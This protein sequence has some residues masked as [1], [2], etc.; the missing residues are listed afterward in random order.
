MDVVTLDRKRILFSRASSDNKTAD[1][2]LIKLDGSGLVQL[3]KDTKRNGQAALSSD[4]K[5]IVFAS[6]RDSAKN[7]I[8]VM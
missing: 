4:G 5:R 7:Q 8:Y 6:T 2:F 1:L 3:T